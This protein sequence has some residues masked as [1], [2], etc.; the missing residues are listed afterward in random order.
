LFVIKRKEARLAWQFLP[1]VPCTKKKKNQRMGKGRGKFAYLFCWLPFG[2]NAVLFHGLTV[3]GLLKV[4][5]YTRP[6]FSLL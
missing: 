5:Y 3:V 6:F 2:L 1:M 4:A